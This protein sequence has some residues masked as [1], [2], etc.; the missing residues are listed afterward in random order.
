MAECIPTPG[1]TNGAVVWVQRS[2]PSER[3]Q[4]E[5]SWGVGWPDRDRRG[6]WS[7]AAR[8]QGS[9]AHTTHI[10]FNGIKLLPRGGE[11]CEANTKEVCILECAKEMKALEIRWGNTTQLATFCRYLSCSSAAATSTFFKYLRWKQ[12][13]LTKVVLNV[14]HCYS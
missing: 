1:R 2:W 8:L 11:V 6:H 3:T 5:G 4:Q 7:R 14:R 13:K 12:I 9:M 10:S